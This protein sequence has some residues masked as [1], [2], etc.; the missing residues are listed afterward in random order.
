MDKVNQGTRILRRLKQGR[1][2][3]IEL[4][5]MCFRYSARIYEL[6][7]AGYSIQ[8]QYVRHGVW[9]YWLVNDDLAQGQSV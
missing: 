7:E 8:R 9:E 4:N 1:V 5:R 2:S 6:R 3:N